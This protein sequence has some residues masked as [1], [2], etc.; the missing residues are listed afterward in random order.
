M[1]REIIKNIKLLNEDGNLNETGYARSLILD[2]DRKDIKANALR[3]KEWDYY[4]IYND[5]YG[6]ALTLAD[7]SYMSLESV[8]ILDFKNSREKTVSPMQPL[9]LGKIN[10]PSSSKEGDV[11]YTSKK[12]D[13]SYKHK[14]GKRILECRM[15]NFHDKKEFICYLELDEE[16]KDSM[17]IAT[18]FNKDKHFYY[19]QKIVGFKVCGYFQLGDF[20]YEFNKE[21]TRGILDWGRGVWT[22]KNTWYWGAGC[23]IVDNHEVGFNIGYGFGDTRAASENAIFYDGILHKI[24][25]ITFNIPKDDSGNYLYIK[26]WTITSS[27]KRFEM[28]FEP[29]LNRASCTDIKLICSDQNQVFGKFNG[30]MIL[31]DGRKIVLK[32]FFA[33]AERV[34]NK[35]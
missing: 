6:I 12:V 24:E 11:V 15:D 35:W 31:D 25:D 17:V 13:L 34:L 29:I 5:E 1:Q 20:K 8:S 14:N 18:P 33:F 23:G 9:S 28:D 27:D 21:N 22:Y 16:P 30:T 32:D 7:N 10:L 19:N 4:L 26:P 2:Y 3:I